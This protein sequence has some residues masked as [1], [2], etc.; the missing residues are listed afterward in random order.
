[1][2]CLTE[3]E[4]QQFQE[5]QKQCS[6]LAEKH[7][8]TLIDCN[9]A[10]INAIKGNP[11]IDLNARQ[12]AEEYNKLLIVNKETIQSYNKLVAEHQQLTINYNLATLG[13][14]T[15][16]WLLAITYGVIFVLWLIKLERK[17]SK[18]DEPKPTPITFPKRTNPKKDNRR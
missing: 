17:M 18:R 10:T 15:M 16:G 13:N 11:F 7:A 8:Q 14:N 12:L 1:M 9:Q 4:T 6:Q 2:I 5:Q 3:E